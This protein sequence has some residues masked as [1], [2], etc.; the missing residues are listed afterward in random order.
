MENIMF[1]K[2]VGIIERELNDR[3]LLIPTQITLSDEEEDMYELNES[4][5]KIWLLIG[6]GN[7]SK[8]IFDKLKKEYS[9]SEWTIIEHDILDALLELEK[10]NLLKREYADE[11]KLL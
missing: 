11:E 7:T 1:I 2:N 6:N 8:G 3:Y 10:L 4:L 9:P 5:K